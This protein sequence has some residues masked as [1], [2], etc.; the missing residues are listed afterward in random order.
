MRPSKDGTKHQ[1]TAKQQLA[2]AVLAT[3]GTEREAAT[4][5]KCH[6]CTV[7]AWKMEPLFR[8]ALNI[9][10]NRIREAKIKGIIE[11]HLK[12][13][14]AAYKTILQGIEAGDLTAAKWF[15]EKTSLGDD[16]KKVKEHEQPLSQ[17]H[18]EDMGSI[19]LGV[20]K[21]RVKELL[22]WEGV[23]D[24]ERQTLEPF[25]VRK[26]YRQLSKDYNSEEMD[27]ED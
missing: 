19:L 14:E 11:L 6:R 3:G 1:I 10:R 17:I 24:L 16:D 4:A 2:V 23:D 15:L 22:D 20:V 21:G 9:E 8:Q 26:F 12:L 18:E 13:R 25:M 7:S 5:A 27:N